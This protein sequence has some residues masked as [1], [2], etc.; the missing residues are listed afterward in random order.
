MGRITR[1]RSSKG[2]VIVKPASIKQCFCIQK[3]DEVC[4]Y[5]FFAICNLIYLF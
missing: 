1:A 3:G 2:D 5:K 4:V